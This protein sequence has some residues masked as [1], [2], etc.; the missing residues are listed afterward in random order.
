MN[1]LQKRYRKDVRTSCLDGGFEC[2]P[3]PDFSVRRS[4]RIGESKMKLTF[5]GIIAIAGVFILVVL[6][7]RHRGGGAIGEDENGTELE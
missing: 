4:R 3:R 1:D 6:V 2:H 7:L 5:L